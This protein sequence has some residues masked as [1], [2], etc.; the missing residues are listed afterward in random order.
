M[1]ITVLPQRSWEIV[2]HLTD[3][4]LPSERT[5]G[6]GNR[7]CLRPIRFVAVSPAYKLKKYLDFVGVSF[8]V[9]VEILELARP[10]DRRPRNAR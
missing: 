5:K 4:P 9:D 3:S 1:G 8:D 7:H 6:L 10:V 2:R